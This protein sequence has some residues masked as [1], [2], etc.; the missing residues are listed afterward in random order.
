MATLVSFATNHQKVEQT[1]CFPGKAKAEH[2]SL[3]QENTFITVQVTQ[4]SFKNAMPP[5]ND[6]GLLVNGVKVSQSEVNYCGTKGICFQWCVFA[7]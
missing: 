5:A 3:S 1:C 6:N 4:R 7:K 2:D